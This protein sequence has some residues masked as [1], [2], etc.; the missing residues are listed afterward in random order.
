MYFYVLCLSHPLGLIVTIA[1][2][3]LLNPFI[4]IVN[5]TIVWPE[6]SQRAFP[7]DS[8]G[9]PQGW[10]IHG[11]GESTGNFGLYV[12]RESTWKLR[13]VFHVDSCGFSQR[14]PAEFMRIFG[15]F[16]GVRFSGDSLEILKRNHGK[17]TEKSGGNLRDIAVSLIFSDLY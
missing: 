4:W 9:N 5:S 14:F 8:A 11:G 16:I 7:G 13:G 2:P 3:L 6:V 15:G 12:K 17:S 10:R 1:L